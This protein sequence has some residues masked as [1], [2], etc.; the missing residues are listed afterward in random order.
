MQYLVK[1]VFTLF[2]NMALLECVVIRGIRSFTPEREEK[3]KFSTPVTLLLGQNGCGK[4]TIIECIKYALTGDFPAGTDN[5]RG[6]V[7]DPKMS[8]RSTSKG[9]IKLLF[10]D[11]QQNFITV[12]KFLEVT[13]LAGGKLRFKSLSP[14]IRIQAAN[15]EIRDMSGRC[16]DA[17]MFCAQKLNVSKAILN[18]VIFCH[19]EN[20]S[21]PLEEAKKLKEKFDEIFGSTD[22]NKC[23][24]KFRKL[25]KKKKVDLRVL[26]E[27][28]KQKDLQKKNTEK[29]RE[30]VCE[31]EL[32][33]ENV[34]RE[35][36][37]KQKELEPLQKRL[38]EIN[39]IV[40]TLSTTY[41]KIT[42][43][44]TRLKGLCK[45]CF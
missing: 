20:A 15:G 42:G 1:I 38:D 21:W 44:E 43:L 37:V 22:Y 11:T 39:D 2:Q 14:T 5:G 36:E 40:D 17:N 13:T 3:L 31:K 23:I 8:N 18:N 29:L 26:E 6:F 19:Q 35:I 7:N 27:Q 34:E 33:L 25:I 16:V 9:S 32:R 12:G 4:T 28:V 41:Q 10:K 45:L 30:S 24:E